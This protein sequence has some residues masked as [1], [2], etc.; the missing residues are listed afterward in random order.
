METIG[1]AKITLHQQLCSNSLAVALTV[2]S[3]GADFDMAVDA[4]PSEPSGGFAIL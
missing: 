1:Y 2:D 3:H 4:P